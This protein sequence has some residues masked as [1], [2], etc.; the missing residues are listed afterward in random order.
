MAAVTR[1]IG[2]RLIV[3][4][5][6]DYTRGWPPTPVLYDAV[7]RAAGFT[8]IDAAPTLRRLGAGVAL[9]GDGHLSVEA[10]AVIAALIHPLC[11]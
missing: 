2:A 1:G 11:R 10:H 7:A 4:H 8:F 6:P 5:I 3:V 9:P